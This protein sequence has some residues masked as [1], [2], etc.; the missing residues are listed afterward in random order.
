[1]RPINN[2]EAALLSVFNAGHGGKYEL[3]GEIQ[4][5]EELVEQGWITCT[6]CKKDPKSTHNASSCR[7]IITRMTKTGVNKAQ[8][9][10]QKKYAIAFEFLRNLEVY[11]PRVEQLFRYLLKK[12]IN[13]CKNRANFDWTL[14]R[15]HARY[16][17]TLPLPETVVETISVLKN[18]L[19]EKG[20]AS[21]ASLSHNTQRPFRSTLVTC[22]E[23]MQ[24]FMRGNRGKEPIARGVQHSEFDE[25]LQYHLNGLC[26]VK[27]RDHLMFYFHANRYSISPHTLDWL[28]DEYGVGRDSLMRYLEELEASDYI[29]IMSKE[30]RQKE[31]VL[32]TGNPMN[33]F[34]HV[35]QDVKAI[36]K[37]IKNKIAHWFETGEEPFQRF[38]FT[39]SNK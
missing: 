27:A 13:A 32:A 36:E 10:A 30:Q 15:D 38:E 9:L 11:P 37:Q 16:L 26:L 7:I 24:V 17:Q 23:L 39:R 6:M 3:A 4:L 1:M 18:T 33:S 21:H 29:R 12:W 34:S 14:R 19:V 22:P 35:N 28:T 8:K 2:L 31:Y 25:Y 20:L 5:R